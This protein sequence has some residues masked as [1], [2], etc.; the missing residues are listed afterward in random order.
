MNEINYGTKDGTGKICISSS[1]RLE[2]SQ[3]QKYKQWEKQQARLKWNEFNSATIK[4]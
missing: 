4:R 2:Q 3:C 1:W